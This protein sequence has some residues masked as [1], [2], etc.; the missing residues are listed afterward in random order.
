[1]I[2][3]F[4]QIIVLPRFKTARQAFVIL[5]LNFFSIG[6]HAQSP[7]LRNFNVKDGLPSSEVYSMLQDSKGYMWFATENGVGRYDG[8]SFKTY[9]MK[10]GLADNTTIY[11][12]EDAQGRIWFS[13]LSGISRYYY[14]GSIHTLQVEEKFKKYN[15]T[16]LLEDA[17]GILWFGTHEGVFKVYKN[18]KVVYEKIPVVV[19]G[20]YPYF[21]MFNKNE[22]IG[23]VN[24][25][26]YHPATRTYGLISFN[27]KILLGNNSFYFHKLS[28]SV[29]KDVY[30]VGE[31]D[32]LQIADTTCFKTCHRILNYYGDTEKIVF[33]KKDAKK[34]IWAGTYRNGLFFFP[35]NWNGSDPPVQYLKDKTISGVL[36]DH[37]N[38]TWISTIGD[39]VYFLRDN[40]MIIYRH[41]NSGL[42]NNKI[43]SMEKKNGSI[44]L[45][46]NIPKINILK[47]NSAREIDLTNV[48]PGNRRIT[49]IKAASD[50]S[51]YV[52]MDNHL[53]KLK[54]G[55]YK[56][57]ELI[58]LVTVKCI[59]ECVDGGILIGSFDSFFYVKNKHLVDYGKKYGI[60]PSRTNALYCD[61]DSS[62]WV[63]TEKGLYKIYRN[64]VTYFGDKTTAL[65][66]R[67]VSIKKIGE[68]R[69]VIATIGNGIVL[70]NKER[71]HTITEAD[72]LVSNNCK[73]IFIEN[74]FVFWVATSKGI[75]KVVFDNLKQSTYK[76]KNYTQ[77]DGLT[78][79]ETIGIIK[80]GDTVWVAT[81]DGLNQFI[82][83]PNSVTKFASSPTYITR[84]RINSLDKNIEKSYDLKPDQNNLVID[85]I[86]LSYKS[87]GRM[88]YKY[89][90]QGLD[91]TWNYTPLT[92]VQYPSLPPNAQYN[93]LVSSQNIHGIWSIPI[94]INFI[95]KP[96]FW[97]TWWFLLTTLFFIVLLISCIIKY[98]LRRIQKKE[99]EKTAFNKKIAEMEMK[100][101]RSQMNPHF[102]FN[103]MNAIQHYMIRYDAY[104]AQ[105]YLAKFAKLIR[106]ILDHS[107][108]TYITVEE[109]MES[110]SI[111]LELEKM[112]FDD[113]F[114]YTIIVD[115]ILI[116][117]G[118]TIPSMLIQ[119]FVENAIWHGLVH[120]EDKGKLIVKLEHK[121][122]LM[123]CT[124]EDNGIG[125]KNAEMHKKNET[126]QHKSFGMQ[127]TKERLEIL[128]QQRHNEDLSFIVTDMVDDQQNALG[129]KV[130]IFIVMSESL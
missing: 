106:N 43:L 49:A 47:N 2:H 91:S 64:K 77:D 15:T 42:S 10:D 14:K 128:N 130:E 79:N 33:L 20:T 121:Q 11:V 32:T 93:F 22:V 108:S 12:Q 92:T 48:Y 99:Y 45:G 24:L 69:F 59:E 28:E 74:S 103:S 7:V 82:D 115:P 89:K 95:I 50:G 86:G 16:P 101:L 4:L 122:G 96:L 71:V 76:I 54:D 105:R 97:Q 5:V 87:M 8:V 19:K 27:N 30:K 94:K 44:I 75:S 55:N 98:R 41:E 104:T 62:I 102:I 110:I 31:K 37:E 118:V 125:R 123:I 52:G 58:A 29:I 73:S 109:E 25:F 26:H 6:V 84:I 120:K 88:L 80:T 56:T 17:Q 107:K 126:K 51:L 18:N 83:K 124:I 114:E 13:P 53:G 60:Y 70:M 34:N 39:G 100:A 112:R 3:Y 119:P 116:S 1:M 72:G 129:T 113:K 61:S 81:S 111:Y 23:M 38:N 36:I 90:M 57:I 65:S 85:F 66:K 46:L 9:T 127:I 63:G 21:I 40:A 67:I 35:V 68:E 78:S 117:E